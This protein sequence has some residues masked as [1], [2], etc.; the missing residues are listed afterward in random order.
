M[1]PSTSVAKAV[2]V[3]FHKTMTDKSSDYQQADALNAML[4]FNLDLAIVRNRKDFQQF[5]REKLK[6]MIGFDFIGMAVINADQQSYS[7]FIPQ[8]GDGFHND[9]PPQYP[10]DDSL[11][12]DALN[13]DEPV[14]KELAGAFNCTNIQGYLSR[15]TP[16]AKTLISVALKDRQKKIG[17]LF[18]VSATENHFSAGRLES[19]RHIAVF[20]SA[21]IN[22][23]IVYEIIERQVRE[24][25]LFKQQLE[26]ENLYL[27]QE[28]QHTHNYDEIV[29]SSAA[30]TKVFQL[31]SQVA[32]TQSSVLIL[33]ETGTGKELIA[34]A[35]HNTS[36]RKNKVMVKVNCATLPANLIESELFG[37]ERGSFTGATDRRIGKFELANNSTLFLDEVGEMPPDLQVKLLRALQE[38]EIER[39]GGTATIKINVR[40]VAATN[41]NLFREVQQGRFRSDLFFR[42]N[43]F[44]VT[45]PPLR[46]RTADIPVLA[47]HFLSK[48]AKIGA[49]T[50]Q[51]FSARVIKQLSAYSWPGNVREL[52]HL[53]ERSILLTNGPVINQIFLPDPTGEDD[54]LLPGTCI[55]TIDDIERSYIIS[56]LK[57]SNGKIAGIGGAADM[58]RIPSTT[59]NSKIKRLNIRKGCIV[60]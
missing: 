25:S 58:L 1:L 27:Q 5:V 18:L 17:A 13:A 10:V 11:F 47:A 54:H 49:K 8:E 29:G 50:P 34:R 31:V 41:R 45:I 2:E 7:P 14:V 43:V 3:S 52:E 6:K 24:I 51:N 48:H 56:V 28:L 23:I 53:I 16:T 40:I 59:L 37:H 20:L 55:K 9:R 4:A 21:A 33:G 36:S 57:K 44:P 38:K 60:E 30:M 32:P 26:S 15:V 22:N 39:I 35:I 46:E 19:I 12:V 42:L